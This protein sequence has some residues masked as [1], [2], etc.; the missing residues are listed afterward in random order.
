VFLGRDGLDFRAAITA[1]RLER[2]VEQARL[3]LPVRSRR[4]DRRGD[5]GSPDVL[6]RL[7]ALAPVHAVRG[8]I[9]HGAWSASL[10][11]TQRIE[12]DEYG[13]FRDTVSGLLKRFRLREERKPEAAE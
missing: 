8:N 5:V 11:V 4:N 3:C 6:A 10:P 9:D 1:L 12:I 2:H 13:G 7:G